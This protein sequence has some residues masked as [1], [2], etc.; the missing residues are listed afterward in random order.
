MLVNKRR[1]RKTAGSSFILYSKQFTCNCIIISLLL[2][3]PYHQACHFMCCI[4]GLRDVFS[5][6]HISHMQTMQVIKINSVL[7]RKY[8]IF[9]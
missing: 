8:F 2:A 9:I 7:L 1:K 6:R 3:V 5:H 4:Y